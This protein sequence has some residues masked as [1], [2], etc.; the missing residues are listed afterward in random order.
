LLLQLSVVHATGGSGG[1][2][3]VVLAMHLLLLMMWLLLRRVTHAD[4]RAQREWHA[5][6]VGVRAK[7]DAIDRGGGARTG[8]SRGGIDVPSR[9]LAIVARMLIEA[10]ATGRRHTTLLLV[11]LLLLVL[12]AAL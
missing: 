10:R 12:Y 7:V 8:R 6:R 1:G 11:L 2:V 5:H 9:E 3:A 4:M